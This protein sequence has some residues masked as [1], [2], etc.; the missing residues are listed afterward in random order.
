MNGRSIKKSNCILAVG[1]IVSLSLA[2]NKGLLA[3]VVLYVDWPDKEMPD[4]GPT[5]GL[6]CLP[7]LYANAILR[8]RTL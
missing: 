3:L 4:A 8:N 6:T 2:W 5:N 1:Y 7:H